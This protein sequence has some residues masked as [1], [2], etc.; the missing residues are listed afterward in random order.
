MLLGTA[1]RSLQST[2]AHADFLLIQVAGY[3]GV[4]LQEDQESEWREQAEG[5]SLS[6]SLGRA[7]SLDRGL[8]NSESGPGSGSLS[9][10]GSSLPS[11]SKWD[12][13][14]VLDEEGERSGDGGRLGDKTASCWIETPLSH[15]KQE[16]PADGCSEGE[17]LNWR[18]AVRSF[19]PTEGCQS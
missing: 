1:K 18:K 4:P 3:R 17:L 9:S 12:G 16:H 14:R 13:A 15:L 5:R 11:A 10:V 19:I 7:F 2:D 6:C 8:T